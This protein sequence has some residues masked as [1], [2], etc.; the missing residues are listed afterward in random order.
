MMIGSSLTFALVA[1]LCAAAFTF[2]AIPLMM[3]FFK[4]PCARKGYVALKP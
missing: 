2:L 3:P 4:A 1:A